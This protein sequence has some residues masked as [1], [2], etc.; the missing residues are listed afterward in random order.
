MRVISRVSFKNDETTIVTTDEFESLHLV[1]QLD[2][3]RDLIHDLETIYDDKLK[4]LREKN[5]AL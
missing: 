3:L 2:I 4:E 1:E 5:N